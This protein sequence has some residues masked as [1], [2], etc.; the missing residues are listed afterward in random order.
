M[1]DHLLRLARRLSDEL[2]A[3]SAADVDALGRF[4]PDHLDRLASSGIYGL[5]GPPAAGGLGADR[6]TGNRVVEELARGCL[7]TTFVWLQHHGV[8]RSVAAAVADGK[9][10]H[11]ALLAGLCS[12]RVRAGVAVGGIRP[13]V[14]PLR[15]RQTGAGWELEG[16]VPWVTGW[17]LVDVL[18][19][20]ARDSAGGVTW[21]LIEVPRGDSPVLG[22][23]SIRAQ[24]VALSAV[25]ASRTVTL[26]LCGHL[27]PGEAVTARTTYAAWEAADR[28]GLRGNGSLALGLAAR[29]AA[30]HRDGVSAPLAARI[31]QVRADLDAADKA[32][33]PQLL[34]QARA[35]ASLLAWTAAGSLVVDGGSRSTSAG[36][37]A[38]RAVREAAFLL[39]FA[40]RPSIREVLAESLSC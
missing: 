39:V 14:A 3:P 38:D 13:G 4:P 9:E 20:A 27:V 37:E 12:G 36:S 28:I 26:D 29:C 11:S 21:L 34:A 7:S 2:L 22:G 5:A 32:S 33:H 23:E 17:G 40:T 1:F 8:L 16:S 35:A 18:H 6:E 25:R 19:V 31:D 15:V 30:L 10:E 24:H